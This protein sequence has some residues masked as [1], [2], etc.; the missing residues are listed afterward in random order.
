MKEKQTH[1]HQVD[2][3]TDLGTPQFPQAL[4]QQDTSSLSLLSPA[5][6]FR[7]LSPFVP[8]MAE[9]VAIQGHALPSTSALGSTFQAAAIMH[10]HLRPG[11][12][13]DTAD[14]PPCGLSLPCKKSSTS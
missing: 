7:Q 8:V 9:A 3:T 12:P 11:L 13:A 10:L 14:P 4:F 6:R 1:S 5:R 2:L